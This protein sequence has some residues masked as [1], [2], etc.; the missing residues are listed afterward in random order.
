MDPKV[1]RALR[2]YFALLAILWAICA[3]SI[4][5]QTTRFGRGWPYDTVLYWQKLRFT[6]F[7][8][9]YA[10]FHAP[11]DSERF[12]SGWSPFTYPAPLLVLYLAFLRAFRDPLPV[13]L[14]VIALWGV[15]LAILG[16]KYVRQNRTLQWETLA[17]AL[18]TALFNYPLFFLL[19]RANL[20]GLVWIPSAAAVFCLAYRSFSAAAILI[21]FAASMKIYP[22]VLLLIFISKR[23]YRDFAIGLIA[24]GVFTLGSLWLTGPTI[25]RAFRGVYGGVQS[26]GHAQIIEIHPM[27]IGFDHSLFSC[28]KWL[29]FAGYHRDVVAADRRLAADSTIYAYTVVPAFATF[30]WFAL[31]RRPMLNQI[32]ALSAA[33]VL[34][35]YVSYDYTLVS[36]IVPFFLLLRFLVQSGGN[37]KRPLNMGQILSLLLPFVFI[38]GP[39]SFLLA[40]HVGYGGQFKALALLWL[41]ICCALLPMPC[42]WLEPAALDCPNGGRGGVKNFPDLR[43]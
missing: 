38:F 10:K 27:D 21:G 36:M 35:P 28:T 9:F 18:A 4:Y 14:G 15:L 19:D 42:G 8:G 1:A 11:G 41:M 16:T 29:R 13:Y 25:E 12:F 20:E 37:V 43:Q 17:V 5:V 34:L 40:D 22:A 7:T 23:R 39:L 3:I 2:W 6:D 30:Y 33:S 31:R 32:L 26:F 24:M